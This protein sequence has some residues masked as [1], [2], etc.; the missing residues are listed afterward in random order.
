[1]H[2]DTDTDAT[3]ESPLVSD[4]SSE[5]PETASVSTISDHDPAASAT[6][7]AII[8]T[9]TTSAQPSL[10]T[11]IQRMFFNKTPTVSFDPGTLAPQADGTITGAVLG[12]DP[13]GDALVYTAGRPANGGT[14]TISGNGSFVYKPGAQFAYDGT[15]LFTVTVSDNAKANG[16]HVHGFLGFLIAGYGS[17]A[18][19]SVSI[20]AASSTAGG[21]YGWVSPRET[22]FTGLAAL[23]GTGWSIYDS[24]GHNGWGRRTPQAVSFVDGNMVITGDAAGNTAG[25][26]WGGG[27]KYGAWEV[28]MRVP[29]GAADYHAVAL[30]WPDAENWP[31]GG[32]IDFVEII[33]DSKRQRVSHF[34]HYSAQNLQEAAASAVD[35]TQWHNYAVSWTPQAITIYID[36]APVYQS[37]TTSHFPPGP[38]HLTLQLD[39]SEK[40]PLNLSSGAQM[41]VAW[42]RQY[43]LGQIS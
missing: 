16:W 34:L 25:M 10:F 38:M 1:M 8:T 15:D 21:R 36:G 13:D 23:S 3:L 22:R 20:G 9:A 30:L 31:V 37:I 17:T 19:T 11:R 14:V 7:A 24:P 41:V 4:D 5:I 2:T 18:T 39:A 27:Q 43:T 29:E 33:G 32:E 35:A 26:A 42:A 28:R 6:R 12:S 40:R